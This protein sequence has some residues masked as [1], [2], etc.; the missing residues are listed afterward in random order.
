MRA[1]AAV[2]DRGSP[3]RALCRIGSRRRGATLRLPFLH[4][5][6]AQA[7]NRLGA[8]SRSCPGSATLRR[9]GTLETDPVGYPS[10]FRRVPG[11][12]DA[13]K[14]TAQR[15]AAGWGT[16]TGS[17]LGH[18]RNPVWIRNAVWI[19]N[20]V[21]V[22]NAAWIRNAAWTRNPVWVRNAAWFRNPAREAYAAWRTATIS[23]RDR[24]RST[25]RVRSSTTCWTCASNPCCRTRVH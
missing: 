25:W 10:A 18:S 8:I 22:R 6:W 2:G 13:A 4:A 23:R 11:P 17:Q 15:V 5:R 21:W 19:R 12:S 16:R 20:P 14:T 1:H 7:G 9:S 24:T 3:D